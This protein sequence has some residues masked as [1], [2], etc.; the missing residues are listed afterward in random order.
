MDLFCILFGCLNFYM[1]FTQNAFQF[2]AQQRVI[3]DGHMAGQHLLTGVRKAEI[4]LGSAAVKDVAQ[5]VFH[6]VHLRALAA[7]HRQEIAGGLSPASLAAD[8]FH[9]VFTE[10]LARVVVLDGLHSLDD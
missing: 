9:P 7:G 6:L 2:G 5:Q 3:L 4:D 1:I 10:R 8:F